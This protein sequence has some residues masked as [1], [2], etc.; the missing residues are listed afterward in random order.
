MKTT[1]FNS[2]LTVIAALLL[3]AG[4]VPVQAQDDLPTAD[5]QP[6]TG[7]QVE[8]FEL[9]IEQIELERGDINS[10]TA[11]L[12]ELLD[13]EVAQRM[14]GARRD[15]L[16]AS[17][18]ERVLRLAE[19]LSELQQQGFDVDEFGETVIGYLENFP[20][21]AQ[22]AIDRLVAQT[23]F[24]TGELAPREFVFKDQ[25]LFEST[26]AVDRIYRS[27]LTYER[28]AVLYDIETGLE[29]GYITTRVQESAENRSVFLELAMEDARH[30]RAAVSALP[31][32][33]E[34][35][36]W[37]RAAEARVQ[38]AA[39]A[40]QDIIDIM[41]AAGLQTRMYRR[42]VLSVTGEITTDILDVGI[43]ASLVSE[44]SDAFIGYVAGEGPR[45]VL[46]LFLCAL[47]IF[48]FYQLSKLVQKGVEKAMSS[49][50]N[51]MS[52]LLRRMIT[53]S[54]RNLVM[55]FGVLIGISQLGISLAPLLA[56]LGIAGFII[57][58]AL[59]DSLSNFASGVM[60]LMYRPFD[61]GDVVDAAGVRGRVSS[62]SLVNTTFMTLDNQR[63]VVPNNMIWQSVI[64]N[65]TAQRTRRVDLLFGI[66]YGDDIEKAEKVLWDILEKNEA[67]L[68]DPEPL[69]KVHELGESSVNIAVRPWV[70]TSNYWDTY[71]ALT[72]EVKLRFDKEGISIPFPQRDVHIFEQKPT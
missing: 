52:Y 36:Q 27:M 49:S 57:G 14:I 31:D 64:T 56:G 18:V 44:W 8:E 62:M 50:R 22:E 13:Q 12:P 20:A 9:A 5:P 40:L 46:R 60:I 21:E 33:A 3:V 10:L 58:F 66:S 61:V 47:I 43:I 48:V 32:D 59:Q 11:R 1:P 41:N 67:V 42:Q 6:L 29:P 7:G 24:P 65:V 4:P 68:D 69:V 71:W 70:K 63:L 16:W 55:I 53:S 15:Q 25:E 30:L 23:E 45:W 54:V 35:T 17:M 38:S 72:R 19:D 39:G 37:L 34:L 26:E 51:R 2:I 28:L